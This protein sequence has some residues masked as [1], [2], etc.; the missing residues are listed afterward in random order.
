MRK[1]N[2][3][4]SWW[5]RRVLG[6]AAL[7][8]MAVSIFSFCHGSIRETTCDLSL[9]TDAMNRGSFQTGVPG[10]LVNQQIAQIGLVSY[11][12]VGSARFRL[13]SDSGDSYEIQ[14][15][16]ASC[17]CVVVSYDHK[18][19]TPSG[20]VTV[21]AQV[22]SDQVNGPTFEKGIVVQLGGKFAGRN[23]ELKIAGTV[24][25]A[26]ALMVFPGSLDLGA[27][28]AGSDN[29]TTLYVRG[30][31]ALLH[32]LPTEISVTNAAIAT[33]KVNLLSNQNAPSDPLQTRQVTCHIAIPRSLRGRFESTIAFSLC[34][35]AITQIDIPVRATVARAIFAV[36]DTLLLTSPGRGDAQ[37]VTIVLKSLGG[38][39]LNVE[40]ITSDLP[41]ATQQMPAQFGQDSQV[42][43]H[44]LHR[45]QRQTSGSIVLRFT[46]GE[47]LTVP[48]TVVPTDV[49]SLE[50]AR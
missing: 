50:A 14:K 31:P 46:G 10:L 22:R 36:P 48:A 32:L 17:G 42:I 34:G 15:V 8:I 30:S 40:R 16:L 3:G 37:P 18:V 47:V 49:I 7:G 4:T 1:W 38:Q 43:V 11:G 25:Y 24:N 20:P 35:T 12:S 21:T 6:G 19:I 39:S 27:V 9:V 13:S 26:H 33:V 44:L 41:V 5:A 45:I 28:A 2:A 23:I 29:V